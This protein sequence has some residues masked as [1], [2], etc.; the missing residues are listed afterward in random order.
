LHY[1]ISV[2]TG[3][4]FLG[5]VYVLLDKNRTT[6][7]YVAFIIA[8]IAVL[9]LLAGATTLIQESARLQYG[10]IVS[11]VVTGK[12]S[13]TGEGGTRTIGRRRKSGRP[14]TINTINGFRI[15]EVLARWIVTGS[16]DAWV[17]E[18]QYPCGGKS[19]WQR[20]FVD[21]ALWTQ[22]ATGQ[23]INVRV[24]KGQPDSGRLG[25]NP[26]MVLG[27][28]TFGIGAGIGLV[29]YL[30]PGGRTRR[31]KYATAPAVIMS[32]EALGSGE[33]TR[34]KV[35]YA[36][37]APNGTAYQCTDEVYV[38]GLKPGDDCEAVYPVDA[39]DAGTLRWHPQAG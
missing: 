3:L 35:G 18:Y 15:H 36:Y 26:Q 21:H 10:S 8:V 19:C 28:V 22:I 25:E 31:R 17:V 11:G 34:W 14:P 12:L 29:A 16:P 2:L 7:E 20:E 37:F 32:V 30:V 24:A 5:A 13:S 38:P 23:A 39:P 9:P 4:L 33:R 27:A 6:R 1:L